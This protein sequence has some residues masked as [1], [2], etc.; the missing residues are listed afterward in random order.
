MNA[1]LPCPCGDTED[2]ELVGAA[3][4]EVSGR[5]YLH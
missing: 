5:L 1:T 4:R 2:S 3:V